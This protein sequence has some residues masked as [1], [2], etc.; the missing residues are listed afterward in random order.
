MGR[1]FAVGLAVMSFALGA[2]LSPRLTAQS[3]NDFIP[4]RPE[5]EQS[6]WISPPESTPCEV[7]RTSYHWVMCKGGTWRNLTNGAGYRVQ[8][9]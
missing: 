1:S 2:W 3:D 6:I 7:E 5:K 9:K 8:P 4:V